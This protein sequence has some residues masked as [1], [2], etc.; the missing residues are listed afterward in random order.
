MTQNITRINDLFDELVPA[1]GKAENL[2]GE[3]VRAAARIAYRYYNDGDMVGK[4]YG[5]ETC[6]PAARFLLH[7]LPEELTNFI[8]DLWMETLEMKYE[9]ALEKFLGGIAD[10]VE[11]HPELRSKPTGDMWNYR[12]PDEDVDDTDDDDYE[13]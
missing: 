5:K 1:S 13:D 4:G 11:G 6:N 12:N 9:A 7:K 2:A 10:Y 8:Y 3:I